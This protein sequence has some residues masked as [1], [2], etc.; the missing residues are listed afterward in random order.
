MDK[1][2]FYFYHVF[3]EKVC[4]VTSSISRALP[5]ALEMVGGY[6]FQSCHTNGFGLFLLYTRLLI[7]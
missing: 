5:R 7:E 1:M 6:H 2:S 4:E 3:K